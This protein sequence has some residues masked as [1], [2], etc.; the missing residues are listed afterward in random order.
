[1]PDDNLGKKTVGYAKQF[2]LALELPIV[3]VGAIVIGGGIGYA[4]D[5]WWHTA[6][7]LMIVGAVARERRSGSQ[8]RCRAARTPAAA[9]S[10][11]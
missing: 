1:M 11:R 9:F 4:L 5:R 7:W 10:E 8:L 6:P 3:F 2:S